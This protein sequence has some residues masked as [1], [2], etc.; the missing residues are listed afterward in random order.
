M[1]TPRLSADTIR[2]MPKV[3][4]H[5]H[6]DGGLRPTTIV[7]LARELGD[8][9]LPTEDPQ[10]LGQWFFRGANRGNLTEYLEGFSVTCSVMQTEDALKR[11]ARELLEDMR[12]DG[13]V[14][15][16]V[17]FAPFLH[18][19]RGLNFEQV[20]SAVIAGLE[21]GTRQTGVEWGIIICALRNLDPALSLEMA[22]L[23]VSFRER[24]CVGFDLAGDEFGHPPKAH[25][26]A[27]HYCQRENFNI[28]IHAGEAFGKPSIWQALQFCG[29]HRIGHCTR[30][31][32]DM[33]IQDG[34]VVSMGT[35]AAYVRD[36]R[37]PLEI[38]LSSNVHTGA[39]ESLTA[40]PFRHYFDRSFRVTL[41][42][43]NR[44][45]SNTT[46]SREYQIAHEVFG[47]TADD[48]EKVSVNA[49]KSAFVG[50]D[51]RLALIYGAVKSGYTELR[52]EGL[53]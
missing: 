6:L 20:L 42:T 40:H 52:S 33:T 38:C 21:E 27:F 22:E 39:V 4:L 28:T 43:D 15:T 8:V 31:A 23:A 32:E 18:T 49:M 46:L 12:D 13:V 14:Y 41:N 5:D 2:R 53:I 45:M 48:L 50:F 51:K 24:G 10:E 29:A 35:L 1:T 36:R 25:L 3:L 16:E 34:Q 44:L 7:E 26:D 11:V 30:L 37:I 17:R 9:P 19:N 47:L